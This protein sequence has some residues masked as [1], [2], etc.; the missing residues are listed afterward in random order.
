[1]PPSSLPANKF[2]SIFQSR[3][4]S[5]GINEIVFDDTS[6]SERLILRS[7]NQFLSLSAAGISASSAINTQSPGI[8]SIRPSTG[9]KTPSPPVVPKR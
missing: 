1:M 7:G 2:R 6:G 4:A 3:S 9:L 8:Q 5:G